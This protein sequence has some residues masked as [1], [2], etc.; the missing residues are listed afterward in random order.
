MSMW[1]WL[2]I[3]LDPVASTYWGV[4]VSVAD[5]VIAAQEKRIE[6]SAGS[7]PIPASVNDAIQRSQT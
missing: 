5:G 1:Q 4:V 6:P 7:V 3:L 2:E